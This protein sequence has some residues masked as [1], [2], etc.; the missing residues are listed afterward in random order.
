MFGRIQPFG[1][2]PVDGDLVAANQ[3]V[4]VQPEPGKD[5]AA[6]AVVFCS[7]LSGHYGKNHAPVKVDDAA[8]SDCQRMRRGRKADVNFVHTIFL[9]ERAVEP[10]AAGRF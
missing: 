4:R 10:A 6:W 3:S 2:D 1:E 5:F 7:G 9:A 8:V